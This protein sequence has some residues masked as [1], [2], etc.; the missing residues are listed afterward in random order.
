METKKIENEN[1][2]TVVWILQMRYHIM[3]T[4]SPESI[5]YAYS[6]GGG[7][8]RMGNWCC[9]L[10]KDRICGYLARVTSGPNH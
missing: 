6:R 5:V 4:C 9:D 10:I 2:E 8:R 1:G 7:K 3:F